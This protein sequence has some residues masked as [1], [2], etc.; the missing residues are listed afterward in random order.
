MSSTENTE[1]EAGALSHLSA[2]LG[3][4]TELLD[5]LDN[6]TQYVVGFAPSGDWSS[7]DI[8]TGKTCYG[9]TLRDCLKMLQVMHKDIS[10]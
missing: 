5:F 4:D 7:F 9:K 1:Q 10:A 2:E 3:T 6:H 8:N